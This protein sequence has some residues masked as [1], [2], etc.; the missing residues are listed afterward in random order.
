MS[1][2]AVQTTTLLKDTSYLNNSSQRDVSIKVLAKQPDISYHPDEAKWKARTARRLQEDPS[3]PLTALPEGFPSQLDSP[4]VWEGKDWD[5]EKQ[6]VY[7]LSAAQ[8]K[9]IDDAVH[10]FHGAFLS[11]TYTEYMPNLP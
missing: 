5:S 9:E 8:L 2:V 10:H 3:L 6:W 7:E 4:L 1:P 11:S